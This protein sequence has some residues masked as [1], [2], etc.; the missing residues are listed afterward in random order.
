MLEGMLDL[1]RETVASAIVGTGG[2]LLLGNALLNARSGKYPGAQLK[3]LIYAGGGFLMS[4]AAAR[5]LSHTGN[6][7]MAI[8]FMG[9]LF[10][11]RGMYILLRERAAERARTAGK[12]GPRE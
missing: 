7:G 12:H 8:S 2:A 3:G 1:D 4:A 6:R 11:L 5:W 10:A 9:T